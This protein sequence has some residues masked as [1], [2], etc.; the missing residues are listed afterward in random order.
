LLIYAKIC[1]R[2]AEIRAGIAAGVI[3]ADIAK[4]MP[5]ESSNLTRRAL[6]NRPPIAL[7]SEH[8]LS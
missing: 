2:I 1:A 5:Q 3:K 7:H 4:R 8:Q 6:S